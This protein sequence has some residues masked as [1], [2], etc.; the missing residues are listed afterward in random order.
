M[1]GELMLNRPPPALFVKPSLNITHSYCF[2]ATGHFA[3]R[4]SCEISRREPPLALV[5]FDSVCVGASTHPLIL[6]WVQL[7]VAFHCIRHLLTT[8]PFG[9][10]TFC[11]S[12]TS[13]SASFLACGLRATSVLEFTVHFRTKLVTFPIHSSL[14]NA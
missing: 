6:Y 7:C 5:I 4:L 1:L 8:W 9:C 11:C 13:L 10:A 3:Y 2:G 14:H 12:S